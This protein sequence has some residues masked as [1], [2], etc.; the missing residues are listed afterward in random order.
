MI[1]TIL[2][3]AQWQR[4]AALPPGTRS[5]WAPGPRQSPI[6][7]S[8][9]MGGADRIA[10][11]Q[12]AGSIRQLVH[13]LHAVPAAQKNV[14][15][16][17]SQTLSDDPDFEYVLVIDATLMRVHQH[18]TGAKGGLTIRPSAGRAAV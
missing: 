3:D 18:G 4:I 10:V 12:F 17:I 8:G 11:A 16:R 1:R 6:N 15:E 13:R 7:R 9:V 5:S 2:K 14:W